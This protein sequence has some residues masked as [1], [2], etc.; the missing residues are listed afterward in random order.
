MKKVFIVIEKYFFTDGNT[1]YAAAIDN[2]KIVVCKNRESANF[3]MKFKT[4]LLCDF[5]SDSVK[6]VEKSKDGN[7]NQIILTDGCRTVVEIIEKNL[8]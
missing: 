4:D 7:S 3:W 5:C 2:E 1:D 8:L 6:R